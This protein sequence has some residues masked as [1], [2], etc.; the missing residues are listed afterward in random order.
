MLHGKNQN[1]VTPPADQKKMSDLLQNYLI[2]NNKI[3]YLIVQVYQ[4]S[5]LTGRL[6]VPNARITLCKS[7]TNETYACKVMTTDID[8]NTQPIPVP[9]ASAELYQSPE[10]CTSNCDYDI[11]VEAPGFNRYEKFNIPVYSEITSIQDVKLSPV[12]Q[13]SSV[14]GTQI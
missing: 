13:A 9:T 8:G 2:I 4:D 10:N 7:L 5:I 6:P 14:G 1:S 11:S 12:D 3:G